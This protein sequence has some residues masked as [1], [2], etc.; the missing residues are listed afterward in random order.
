MFNSLK[1]S[2]TRAGV[3]STVLFLFVGLQAAFLGAATNIAFDACTNPAVRFAWTV[4]IQ[5]A[6]HKLKEKPAKP[7]TPKTSPPAKKTMRRPVKTNLRTNVHTSTVQTEDASACDESV[8]E[9]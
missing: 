6:K 5:L 9:L 2:A 8:D 4:V 1:Q 7:A 3:L